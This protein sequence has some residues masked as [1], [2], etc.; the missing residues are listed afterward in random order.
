MPLPDDARPAVVH[1]VHLNDT[2]GAVAD[3]WPRLVT[4]LR[5]LRAQGRLD[6][7]L[8]AGDVPLGAPSGEVAVRLMNRLG[9]DAVALG[10]HRP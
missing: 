3:V 6:L 8:H 4:A 1:L 5:T 2:E 10:N 9:V 7:L